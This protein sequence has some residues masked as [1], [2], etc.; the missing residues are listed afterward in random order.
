MHKNYA[1]EFRKFVNSDEKVET[2]KSVLLVDGLNLFIRAFSAVPTL[3]DNGEHTGA[4]IGF[5]NTLRKI[6]KDYKI[7]KVI[8]AFDGKGGNTRR[9][10]LYKDY[11]GKRVNVGS[12]N[13]FEVVDGLVDEGESFRRQLAILF[14][15]FE[16]LPLH[17]VSMDN[18][19][20]DDVI[21]YI[22]NEVIDADSPVIIAS[23]D[24]DFLSLIKPNRSVYSLHKK[25]LITSD[26]VFE[27]IGYL[28]ANYLIV[29]CFTGNDVSDNI[30]GVNRLGEKTMLK[31]FDM[32]SLE[33]LWTV[34]DIINEAHSNVNK[35][36]KV[37]IFHN[38]VEQKH[39]VYRN[40]DLMQLYEP[41]VSGILSSHIR[42]ILDQ[43]VNS[44]DKI[45]FH[46]F[47]NEKGIA[48][49]VEDLTIWSTIR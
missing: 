18:I 6:V 17:L 7:H 42:K 31:Y 22:A 25:M 3:N 26:N 29:R 37:K 46:R 48:Y 14:E 30:G 28:P 24:K 11:K 5:F 21:A 38:I 10:K 43:P 8:I 15:I 32:K 19:E 13:R 36:T 47:M 16:F 9:R 20:A 33:K 12:F 44:F 35:G 41:P 40:Y 4:I 23:S 39:I 45:G 34:D 49:N 27:E 2:K 1:D